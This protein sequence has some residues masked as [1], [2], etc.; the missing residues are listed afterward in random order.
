M[1]G[2]AA[3]ETRLRAIAAAPGLDPTLKPTYESWP[4]GFYDARFNF[5]KISKPVPIPPAYGLSG[6]P[7]ETYTGEGPISYWN[8]YVA[9][10]QMRGIGSFSEPKLGINI[11]VRPQEDLVKDK[12][13]ALRD[14][15]HSLPAPPP[16]AGS[17]TAAAAARGE[18]LFKSNCARCHTGPKYTNGN[19][20]A[21][22]ETGMEPVHAQRSTTK[23]YRATPLR[24][25]WQHAPY[26]HDGSAATL[27]AVVDHYNTFLKLGLTDAQK[28]DLVEFLKSI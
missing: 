22:S 7:L 13:P 28:T 25:L 5:D 15:Q 4:K 14:Y 27:V 23:K 10:T 3:K 9:V 1:D 16:P 17:F 24:S 26:F 8:Q 21:P 18:A 20:H 6:V 12:L 2:A 19:L 11:V